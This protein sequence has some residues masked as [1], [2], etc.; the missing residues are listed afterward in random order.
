MSNWILGLTGG[1]G[2]GKTLVSNHLA[3][4][5]IEIVDADVIA[6][7]VV[8]IGSDGLNA[9]AK[10]FGNTILLEDGSLNRAKLRE[11][12]FADSEQKSWLNNLLHPMIRQNITERLNNA[13]STYVVLSAPLLFENK[14]DALC[15]HTL[16]VDVPVEV[17]L[18]RTATRDSVSAEQVKNIIASQMSR[19]DKRQKA[20]SILDN[21]REIALVL[22]EVE[23]LHRTFLQQ[24]KI[25]K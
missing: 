5:G 17:Q 16:M 3:S 10:H 8:A 22:T 15:N 20:D 14:L 21:H 9:I 6:R 2:A 11:I 23:T 25:S 24:A 7:D 13:K 18:A 19:E 4:L 12:I 1:I